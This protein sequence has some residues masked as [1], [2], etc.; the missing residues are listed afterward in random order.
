MSRKALVIE[1]EKELGQLLGEHLRRW[2]YATS[3]LRAVAGWPTKFLHR[4][5]GGMALVHAFANG[6]ADFR[7]FGV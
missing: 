4:Q 6:H 5:P 7:V 2:G 1:D 3:I